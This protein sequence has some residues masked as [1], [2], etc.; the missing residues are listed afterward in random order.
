MMISA[1]GMAWAKS[2][3]MF[4]MTAKAFCPLP[5]RFTPPRARTI[6]M[7]SSL[8]PATSQRVT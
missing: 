3:V 6:S 1:P 5:V 7:R 4:S 2:V 8:R